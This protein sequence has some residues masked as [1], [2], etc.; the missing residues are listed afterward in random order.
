MAFAINIKNLVAE[1]RKEK[2][3]KKKNQSST[4]TRILQEY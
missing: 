4:I 2:W 1:R 3:K